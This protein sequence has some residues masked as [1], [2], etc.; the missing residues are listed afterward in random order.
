MNSKNRGFTL[1][2]MLVVIGIIAILSGALLMGFGR[3]TKAAQ[4]AKAVETVSQVA[5]AL[6]ILRQKNDGVWPSVLTSFGGSDGSGR[7]MVVDV[8]KKFA[9]YDMLGIAKKNGNPVGISRCGV[10]DPWAEAVLKRIQNANAGSKVPSGGTVQDHIIYFAVDTDGDGITVA[11]VG[12]QAVQVR[13]EAIAW[14]A[15]ADGVIAPYS[16]RG[17]SDDIYSWDKAKEKR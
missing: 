12:G 16:Q 9:E 4:R 13:A 14:C 1:I 10:V 6:V 2:E 3:V 15:G 11:N 8:A 17:R 7:G 5:Q